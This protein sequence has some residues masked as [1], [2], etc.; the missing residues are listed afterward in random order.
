MI[1]FFHFA[2]SLVLNYD[3][4]MERYWMPTKEPTI[5]LFYTK[6]HPVSEYEK[7]AFIRASTMAFNVNF[8]FVNCSEH[9]I[10][11]KKD[12]FD[13]PAIRLAPIYHP[14]ML[15]FTNE[16]STYAILEL[17]T[18]N[19]GARV[20]YPSYKITNI[21][22]GNFFDFILTDNC[23]VI[24][25]INERSRMSEILIPTINELA[26]IFREEKDMKFGLTD[27]DKKL[28]FCLTVNVEAVP[29]IRVYTFGDKFDFKGTRE[30]PYLL[31][32]VNEKCDKQRTPSGKIDESIINPPFKLISEFMSSD[33][34][35]DL[36]GK[37]DGSKHEVYKLIM[38]RIIKNGNR[39]IDKDIQNCESLLKDN[40]VSGESLD[41]VKSRLEALKLFQDLIPK[42]KEQ[43]RDEL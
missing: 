1:L 11:D 24:S 32:F 3:Q 20:V 41:K 13:F 27:C 8:L 21:S 39:I 35:K 29:T 7:N 40:S 26:S 6:E 19:T 34:K 9:D 12:I 16:I 38:E 2:S 23:N 5:A 22:E 33:S 17:L 30:L 14:K 18:S 42:E 4:S 25:F 15:V 36:L 43:T 37:I 10:C 28:D 31:K